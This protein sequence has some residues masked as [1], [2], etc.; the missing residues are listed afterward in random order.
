MHKQEEK[1]NA[2]LLIK[3]NHDIDNGKILAC[4]QGISFWG[5]VDPDSS[6]IIEIHHDQAGQHVRDKI[7][8]MQT[9]RGSCSGS[10]VLLELAM[11]NIA[12]AAIVF[13]ELE[14]TLTL[15]ALV[16]SWSSWS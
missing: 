4:K 5:G 15:G 3:G 13:T 12:P 1:K 9:S 6:K 16:S 10:G 2:I 14:E 7:V 8:M 11:K